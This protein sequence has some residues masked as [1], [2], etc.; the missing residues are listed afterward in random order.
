METGNTYH[1]YN[2]ANG[3]EDLFREPRNYHFFLGKMHE[4]LSPVMDILA[5]CL[6]PNH[7]HMAIRIPESVE[8]AERDVS[9][10]GLSQQ[11]LVGRLSKRMANLLSC[12]TQS[13]NHRYG[14]MGSLFRPNTRYR[15]VEDDN[16]L[17]GLIHYI[18]CNPVHHG[19]VDGLEDWPYSS[20][21]SYRAMRNSKAAKDPVFKCFGGQL[22]FL[23]QHEQPVYLKISKTSEERQMLGLKR[24]KS[25]TQTI[26]WKQL[27]CENT[28]DS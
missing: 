14:R 4:H 25:L 1:A 23:R 6:M 20:F 11:E 16:D 13:F 17:S 19:F 7:F 10:S 27:A 2:H 3:E 8:L 26:N 12:Y 24:Q 28:L 15:E 22:A 5:Y 21:S 9:L 18:H